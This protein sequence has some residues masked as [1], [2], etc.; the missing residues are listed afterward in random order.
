MKT[1]MD[2]SPGLGISAPSSQ[3]SAPDAL[4]GWSCE[5]EVGKVDL[6]FL[7]HHTGKNFASA[8][9]TTDT[10]PPMAVMIWA[11]E[12][13][14]KGMTA[15]IYREKSVSMRLNAQ[16]PVDT[17]VGAAIPRGVSEHA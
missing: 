12:L 7:L 14:S 13:I 8:S 4:A 11:T 10:A 9:S 16:F 6:V 5:D 3:A 2:R 15:P 1:E 17:A